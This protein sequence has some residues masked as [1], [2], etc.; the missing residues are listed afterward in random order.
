MSEH[1]TDNLFR[2]VYLPGA[3]ELRAEDDADDGRLATLDIQFARFNA[4]NEIDS[5]WEGRFLERVS[6]GAFKKTM[7]ERAGQIVSLFNH[8]HDPV[9]GDKV[10]GGIDEMGERGSGPF[11]TVGLD[12]TSFG[13]DLLP[14][15]RRGA[16]G[17]SYMFRV[18]K[19][20]WDDEPDE[21]EHNAAKLPERTITEVKLFE[22]GPVTFPA[23]EST[24]VG[25]RSS[26]DRFWSLRNIRAAHAL[27]QPAEP[28]PPAPE[29]H[30]H[31]GSETISIARA[32]QTAS[33]WAS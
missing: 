9:I 2:S 12:D 30:P 19:E 23:D 27:G 4:W 29:P 17:A 15:L 25:V 1:L 22:A 24:T 20:E 5:Y 26:T 16:Y 33:R 3:V 6:P 8:G 32:R 13:R 14:G 18:V 7:G 28:T 21:S 10:L 11:L 31:S